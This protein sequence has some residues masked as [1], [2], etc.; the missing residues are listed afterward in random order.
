[1]NRA[2]VYELKP[3]KLQQEQIDNTIGATRFIYNYYLAFK[4]ELYELEG[5]SINKGNCYKI[6][7]DFLKV[8]YPF[9]KDVDSLALAISEI[10][11]DRAF[12]N[13]FR[14]KKIGFPRF[15]S[16]EKA[17]LSYTTNNQ[18][19]S[20]R[21]IDENHIKI[22]KLGIV[23]INMHRSIPNEFII[24][25][26]TITKT[27]A[28]KYSISILL[29]KEEI[30]VEKVKP[31]KILGIDYSSAN[32]Y[33]DSEFSTCDYNGYYKA[34]EK[35]LKKEQRKL[36]NCERRSNNYEKQR[37]KVLRTHNKVSN[38][39]KDFLHKETRKLANDYDA[40]IIEDI[41]M[42]NISQALS[43]GKPT[44]DNGF[45]MFRSF[46][47][48][49]LEEKGKHLIKV[50]KFYPSSKKC[51]SCGNIK[52]KLSLNT[53]IYICEACHTTIDR[54]YNAALNIKQEGI[55]LLSLA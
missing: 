6:C 21:I 50:D 35:K 10:N 19:G 34:N 16:K 48:Y 8:A 5:I 9:L 38:S 31:N 51:S 11:L 26:A 15:K 13:F 23:K 53:R 2:Y 29:E 40:I 47:K 49:K 1:M 52:D 28:L 33:V 37:Q 17:K 32:L 44:N 3:N 41:N 54:D 36:S 55:R 46:L 18:K 22:P 45:G 42:Q 39:R 4:K 7:N 12:T 27:R 30:K 43:L 25:S 20:I 14:D 24:K